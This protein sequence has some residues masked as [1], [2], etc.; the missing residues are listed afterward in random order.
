MTHACTGEEGHEIAC[1]VR[2][3]SCGGV[4]FFLSAPFSL[5]SFAAHSTH[6]SSA[7]SILTGTTSWP[8]LLVRTQK[9]FDVFNSTSDCSTGPIPQC[10]AALVAY[11]RDAATYKK[12]HAREGIIK[13]LFKTVG[14]HNFGLGGFRP[15]CDAVNVVRACVCIPSSLTHVA[16]GWCSASTPARTAASC[17][18][19]REKTWNQSNRVQDAYKMHRLCVV[20]ALLV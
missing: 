18:C 9:L 5:A 2:N 7:R 8:R 15:R 1:H 13:S 17:D 4:L 3:V 11:G 19:G 16:A 12:Q 6:V 20:F 14:R 10:S